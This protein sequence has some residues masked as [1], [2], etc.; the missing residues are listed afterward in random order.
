[1]KPDQKLEPEESHKR[2][3][4]LL[5]LLQEIEKKDY[6]VH[7]TAFAQIMAIREVWK[8]LEIDWSVFFDRFNEIKKKRQG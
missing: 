2:I 6:D 4:H 7:T 1:M 3:M 8:D 5:N